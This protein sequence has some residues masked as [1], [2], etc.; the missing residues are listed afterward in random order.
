MTD[1]DRPRPTG[2]DARLDRLERELERV[3]RELADVRALVTT[4]GAKA[5]PAPVAAPLPLRPPPESTAAQEP[6]PPPQPPAAPAPQPVAQ[7]ARAPAPVPAAAPPGPPAPPRRTLGQLARDW[8][9][10]GARGFAIVGGAVLALGIGFFFVLAANRGWVDERARVALGAIASAAVFGG[11]VLLR[12]RYG[13][14]WSALA[15]VGAGIAGAYATLAAAAARYDL[16]PDALAL[17]LAAVIAAVA[18]VV[19]I[20][21]ES[22]TIAALGLLGAAL[23]PALQSLDTDLTWESAA[24]A[25][26]VLV[27][28]GIVAVPRGWHELLVA[29]SLI[30]GAQVELLAAGADPPPVSGGTVAVSAAL[31]LC[32]LGIAVG[33]QVVAARVDVDPLSLAYAVAAFG[34]AL[35]LATQVFDE[36]AGRGVALL[37]AAALWGALFAVLA[38]RRQPDLASVLGASALALAAVGTADLVSDSALTLAWAAQAVVLSALAYRLR[39]ARLQISG[40]AYATLALLHTVGSEGSADLLFDAGADHGASV[41]PLAAT[42]LGAAAVAALAPAEHVARGEAGLLAFLAELRE[43]LEESRREFRETFAYVAAALATLAASFALV[44]V[45]YEWGHV[46]ATSLAALVGGV[47]LGVAGRRRRDGLAVAAHAW[48]AATLVVA[49]AFD[50]REFY[51]DV[52]ELSTGGWSILAT[53]AATLGGAYALRLSWPS[54]RGRDL[55]LGVDAVVAAAAAALGVALLTTDELRAGLALLACA[56][57]YGALAAYVFS[58]DGFRDTATVLWA[59]ALVLLVGA[60]SLL[61]TDSIWR[62][63]EILVTAVLVGALAPVLREWRLWLAAA[64]LGVGTSLVVLLVQ[65]QPWRGEGEIPARLAVASAAA[66]LALALLADLTRRRARWRDLTSV[67]GAVG[68]VLLLATERV[69]LDDWRATTFAVALTGG[70]IALLARPLSE[71]RLWY[72]GGLV[73]AL[74]TIATMGEVTPIRQFFE[75]SASPAGGLWVLG[76]CVVSLAAVGATAPDPRLRLIVE[77]AAAGLA[78]YAVSLGILEVAERVSR[79]SV[80]TDFERGHTA[81]SAVWALIGLALLVVGLV[82]GSVLVRYGGLALFA[83]SL[84][85]IFLY[86]LASLSSVARAFSFILVGALLL[87]GGFFLQR[88]SDRLGPRPPKAPLGT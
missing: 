74:A 88:L 35:A 16:V 25:V 50:A 61:I 22:Q 52:T 47:L 6:P 12:A 19:A 7:P 27:A 58:R 59:L 10:V 51:D 78:L 82:R 1:G 31:V 72:A 4:D 49:F 26:V 37:A 38:V 63:V 46:A 24:F 36:R 64:S 28:A 65:V 32:L 56:V 13:Q 87:A 2:L 44:S 3:G 80:E 21:W 62:S 29:S 23:A 41:L 71:Q 76:G 39:D 8:D 60:E 53:G 83:L 55:V 77:L 15:A 79:A 81:V 54:S 9:L 75:S 34:A 20:R 86:D 45:S 11:G 70:A 69:I 43:A 18:T 67:V 42:A 85:K 40:A 73:T 5:E 30:V 33:R 57:V 48:L 17:P 66:V 14:Y 68:I 84:A